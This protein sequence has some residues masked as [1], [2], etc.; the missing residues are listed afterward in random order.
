MNFCILCCQFFTKH[1]GEVPQFCGATVSGVGC[2]VCFFYCGENHYLF[3]I[4]S[5]YKKISSTDVDKS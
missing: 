4:Q 1:S 3:T 5:T 2:L